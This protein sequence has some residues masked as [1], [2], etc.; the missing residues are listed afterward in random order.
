[1][2]QE[3]IPVVQFLPTSSDCRV[4]EGQDGT[5]CLGVPLVDVCLLSGI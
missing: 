1:M 2:G 4:T 3:A 5:G